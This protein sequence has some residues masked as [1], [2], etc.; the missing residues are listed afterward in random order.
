MTDFNLFV[1]IDWSGAKGKPQKGIQVAVATPDNAAPTIE[2]PPQVRGQSE[3]KNWSREGVIEWLKEKKTSGKRV[4][5]GMDFAF[6]HPWSDGGYYPD[7]ANAPE[8]APVL[9]KRI[10]DANDKSQHLYGGGVFKEKHLREY[11]HAQP[12]SGG[13]G[14]KYNPCLRQT[15]CAAKNMG[16]T[17]SSTFKCLGVGHV[18][19]GSLAGMRFLHHMADHACIWPFDDHVNALKREGGLL[20]LVEIYPALYFRMAEVKKTDEQPNALND[21]L[22]NIKDCELSR[23]A[24]DAVI[25]AAALRKLHHPDDIFPID[26]EHRDIASREGW[27]FGASSSKTTR[28]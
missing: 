13:K 21:T 14:K 10:D 5:V 16:T 6:A 19:T 25:S 9:W 27:I 15:E 26:E 17:P 23:D 4:L 2:K 7:L 8:T 1:G 12:K 22:M 11:Y 3:I 18:G 24:I 28:C 20:V